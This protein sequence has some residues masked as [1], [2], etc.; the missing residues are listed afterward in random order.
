MAIEVSYS[1]DSRADLIR[2][3]RFLLHHAATPEDLGVAERA[4]DAIAT[5]VKALA[6]SPFAYRKAGQSPFLRE[7]WIPF[8]WGG[9]AAL[10]AIEDVSTIAIPAGRHH[11]E[12]DYNR[13]L[14]Q[15]HASGNSFSCSSH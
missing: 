7:L 8:D 2:L 6:R 15:P 5:A 11:L 4:P 3:S 9:Y 13:T 14:Q 1:A 10:F 12:D